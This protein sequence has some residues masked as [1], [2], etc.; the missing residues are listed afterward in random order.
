MYAIRSYYGTSLML[1]NREIDSI[2]F[3]FELINHKKIGNQLFER[4]Y[5]REKV[6]SADIIPFFQFVD[7]K[8]KAM[9]FV[10]QK[11]KTDRRTVSF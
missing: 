3:L 4:H 10:H 2:H 8:L 5:K 9:K 6:F 11:I 7:F 1:Q